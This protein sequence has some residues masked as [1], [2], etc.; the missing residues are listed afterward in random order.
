MERAEAS[1]ML[2][3]LPEITEP[4]S[5]SELRWALA[6]AEREWQQDEQLETQE[7]M[8]IEVRLHDGQPIPGSGDRFD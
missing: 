2:S 6:I 4:A 7:P 5:A 3:A 8:I 1:P